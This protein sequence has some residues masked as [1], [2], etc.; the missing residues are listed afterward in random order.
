MLVGS[1]SRRRAVRV[2][3]RVGHQ[4]DLCCGGE[5]G[6]M[7]DGEVTAPSAGAVAPPAP[8]GA[9]RI[10]IVNFSFTPA[11]ITVK[12]G[13]AVQ[14]ANGDAVAHTVDFSGNTSKVLNRGDTYTRIFIRPGVYPYICSIHPF[15]HGIV[16]V[17][18]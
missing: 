1:I 17:T 16:T 2:H 5:D 9:M 4:G 10:G 6:G 7:A 12:G 11:S 18:A 3:K 13:Q 14:R 8:A 15:M